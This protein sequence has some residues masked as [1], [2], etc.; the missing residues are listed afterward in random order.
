MDYFDHV[1]PKKRPILVYILLISKGTVMFA[2]D[3]CCLTQLFNNITHIDGSQ[4]HR[5]LIH[6]HNINEDSPSTLMYVEDT[7]Q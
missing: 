6:S 1:H 2:W 5:I 4:N 7:Q 3:V